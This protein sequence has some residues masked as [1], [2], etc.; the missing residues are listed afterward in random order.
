M[1]KR[2]FRSIIA[3]AIILLGVVLVLENLDIVE[4]SLI[5]WWPYIYPVFFIFVGLKWLYQAFKGQN[6][7]WTPIFL[8]VFGSLLLAGQLTDFTFEFL[9]IYK[10][11]PLILVF[12]G[13]YFLGVPRKRR[14]KF[15]HKGNA[16]KGSSTDGEK[17][18]YGNYD[19]SKP[20]WKVEPTNIWNAVGDHTMDFTKAFIPDQDTPITSHGLAGD[21]NII[22]PEHVDFSVKATV[23]AGE[24]VILDQTAQGINRSLTYETTGYQEATRKL[25]FKLKL[26]AGS[27]RVDRI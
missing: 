24:V 3:I 25:T 12:I 6:G 4:W 27:I 17:T 2:F 8:I 18:V 11:W 13:F 10:L 14:M 23:R 1:G 19:Y 16:T 20:N 21:I 15:F 22:L 5:D 7:F 26:N 9:D